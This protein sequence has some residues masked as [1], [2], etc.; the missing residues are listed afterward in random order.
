MRKIL[1]LIDQ[2]LDERNYD[3]FGI[4]TWLDRKWSVEV[5]DITPWAHRRVWANFLQYRL[6]LKT[7]PGY[8]PINSRR[9]FALRLEGLGPVQWFIDFTGD[10]LGSL[11]VRAALARR[12]VR[13]ITSA[14]GLNPLPPE[15][16]RR[17]LGDKLR[18]L[19]RKGPTHACHA[20]GNRLT[21]RLTRTDLVMVSGEKSLPA[22]ANERTTLRV[23]SFDYDIYLKE[24]ARR[25]PGASSEGRPYLVFIDQDY[26]FHP[27]FLYNG[28]SFLTTP[29]RYFPAL[30]AALRKI[31]HAWR[32]DVKIA[33]HPR[34]TYQVR[35][36][37]Y[38]EGFPLEY[39][40]TPALIKNAT[41]VVCH[42]STAVH[43]AVL[44][45]RPIIFVTTADLIPAFEGR[46]IMETA[47]ELGKIPLNLDA[48]LSDVD[49][50]AQAAIDER[51]YEQFKRKYIKMP[52]SPE[53]P[54]WDVVIDR[55][56]SEMTPDPSA[57][58]Q[59]P[60]GWD[61]LRRSHH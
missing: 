49:L 8:C 52:D 24:A 21:S 36:R 11:R 46:S 16:A 37:D 34:A 57:H 33:A 26:C 51:W 35:E 40:R 2:P 56:E 60:Q 28:G 17:G 13:R 29:E 12:G 61:E 53:R 6:K 42:D 10:Y 30:C 38:F 4:Q 50:R 45:K 48:D 31:A 15:D 27:D 43:F 5:W 59:R 58:G 18:R 20:L 41:L 54:M 47:A 9:E 44:F 39:E 7:F 32:V 55:I 3:R 19:A 25:D 22:K 14:P 1:Y 23:H